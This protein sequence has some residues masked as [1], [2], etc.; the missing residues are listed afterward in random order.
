VEFL[1]RGGS[2]EVLLTHES[3]VDAADRDRHAAGWTGCLNR[4]TV[5]L[6]EGGD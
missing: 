4:L 5:T 6:A 1:D 3:F 2:T